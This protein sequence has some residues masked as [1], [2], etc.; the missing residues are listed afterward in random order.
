MRKRV[1]IDLTEIMSEIDN[2]D[3]VNV[4]P[5][6]R[7]HKDGKIVG[8]N[9]LVESDN[10]GMIGT[11]N[12]DIN[13]MLAV[14]QEDYH[15]VD[16]REMLSV[17]IDKFGQVVQGDYY[18]RPDCSRLYVYIY[19]KDMRQLIVHPKTG[20]KEWVN[21]GLR[22]A[23]SYDGSNALKVSSVGYREVCSNGMW[24]QTFANRSY[25]KHTKNSNLQEFRDAID[26]VLEADYDDIIMTYREAMDKDVPSVPVLL[27]E[28]WKNK[29]QALKEYI[30][31]EIESFEGVSAW[32]VYCKAT[33]G[34]THGFRVVKGGLKTCDRYAEETLKNLHKDA[35]RILKV[36]FNK[37]DWDKDVEIIEEQ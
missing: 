8:G 36:D 34:L 7:I 33:R 17:L 31:K 30:I 5:Q 18:L 25:Q 32:D 29:N 13:K 20:E 15:L 16:H 6:E 10:Q 28:V 4:V 24:A 14:F 35:N 12:R 3:L 11:Y 23:N 26:S 19:P 9:I 21:M 22:F 2:V 37:I 1:N 27:E